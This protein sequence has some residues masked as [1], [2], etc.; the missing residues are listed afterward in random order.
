MKNENHYQMVAKAIHYLTEK[1]E[2]HP[3]LAE[4]SAYLG[5]SEFHL[6][7]IFSEW[8]GVS[9]KQFL[10]YLTKEYAKE[11]LRNKS[12]LEVAFS[13]GLSGTSRLHDL[14]INWEGMTPGEYKSLGKG[15]TIYYEVF[16]SPFGLCFIATTDRGICK[17][18]FFDTEVERKILEKQLHDE[19]INAFIIKD[20]TKTEPVVNS[21]FS[22]DQE[23]KQSLKLLLKGSKFQIKVWEALLSI[24]ES[25]LTTYHDVA[26]AIGNPKAVR[27]TATAIAKNNIAYLIPCHRVI[28][29]TGEFGQYRWNED[30]KKALILWEAC[31]NRFKA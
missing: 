22:A 8:A 9:P 2:L 4:L 18:C 24:P 21:I 31:Q 14:I 27:A 13:T 12:V 3:S 26:A 17:L 1:R 29:Q 30:R 23:N 10:Q 20:K 6:Q 15:L 7:R 28:R 25:Q 16:P 11:Q 5:V 19:W